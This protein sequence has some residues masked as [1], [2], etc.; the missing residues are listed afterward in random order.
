MTALEYKRLRGRLG[1]QAAV[2][3]R[4]GLHRVT[5]AKREAGTILITAEAAIAIRALPKH[6]AER[7]KVAAVG[8]KISC[9]KRK[10]YNDKL[11]HG[12]TP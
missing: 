8:A 2:A 7:K 12:A 11:T 1:T 3:A 10:K 5:I 4:L 6:I 9:P